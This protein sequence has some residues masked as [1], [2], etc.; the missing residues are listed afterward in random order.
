MG[1]DEE[2]TEIASGDISLPDDR[3]TAG[4]V[5]NVDNATEYTSYKLV[6]PT[7]KGNG[8]SMQ[9][10][11]IQLH[12]AADAGGDAI[13]AAGD[14][15]HWNSQTPTPS[16]DADEDGWIHAAFVYDGGTDT[17]RIYLN[18]VLDWTGAK[19]PQNGGG[20]LIIGGRN[21]GEAQYRGLIDEVTV[22]SETLL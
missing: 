2:W 14:A 3:N 21:N 22:L 19:R 1:L 18:G 9:I 15:V 12:T 5:V 8:N 20:H 13:I 10:A 11:E 6:F 7:V 4:T 16:P 17:G